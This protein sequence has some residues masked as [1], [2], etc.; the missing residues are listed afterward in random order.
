MPTFTVWHPNGSPDTKP[1]KGKGPGQEDKTLWALEVSLD[2]ETAHAIAPGANI[3]LVATTGAETLGVQGFPNMMK[4]EKSVVDDG[5]AQVISQSSPP[6]RTRSAAR[7]RWRISATPSRRPLPRALPSSPRRATLA[8]PTS[9]EP[10]RQ[11]GE[12]IPYPTVEWPA[13]D[14]LSPAWAAPTCT[15]PLAD[16]NDRAPYL[17]P[18]S[19][20]SAA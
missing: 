17:R 1:P 20:R 3:L 7:S 11:G 12:L 2:V 5:M 15:D 8:Q 18:A 13:S 4:A 19:G 14:P 16:T 10:G 6:P 9:E